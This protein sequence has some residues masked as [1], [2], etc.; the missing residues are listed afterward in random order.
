MEDPDLFFGP[1]STKQSLQEE[2]PLASSPL[3]GSLAP[4]HKFA[5]ERGGVKKWIPGANQDSEHPFDNSH[6]AF[7]V[8]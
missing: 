8:M 1:S 5:R 3:G 2:L 6:D 7:Y 4:T